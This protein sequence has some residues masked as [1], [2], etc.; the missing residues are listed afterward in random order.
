MFWRTPADARDALRLA[1]TKLPLVVTSRP[2]GG[3]LGHLRLLE[4]GALVQLEPVGIDEVARYLAAGSHGDKPWQDAVRAL[5]HL[6]GPELVTTLS[7][8]LMA[9]LA[10]TVYAPRLRDRRDL[11]ELAAGGLTERAA[12]EEHLLTALVPEAF[13]RDSLRPDGRL[14]SRGHYRQAHLWLS[15][16]ATKL[17]PGRRISFWTL[18]RLAPMYRIGLVLAAVA[19]TLLGLLVAVFP[20]L[21]LGLVVA[22]VL[23]LFFGLAF[24]RAYARSRIL[25]PGDPNR[26]GFGGRVLGTDGDWYLHS[27]RFAFGS[28]LT[29]VM[30]GLVVV[31][32]GGSALQLVDSRFLVLVGA[33]VVLTSITAWVGGSFAAAV[34]RAAPR[35]DSLTGARARNP[36]EV[37]AND[38]RSGVGMAVLAWAFNGVVVAAVLQVGVGGG[39]LVGLVAGAGAVPSAVSLFNAWVNYKVAHLWLVLRNRLPWRVVDFLHEA[40]LNGVLRQNGITYEFRHDRLR[41]ALVRSG[42]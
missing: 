35:L 31:V 24:V 27:G 7:S 42:R 21:A 8:P 13:R 32:S 5:R 22:H 23:G 12:I 29:V 20:R 18:S 40:H 38:R 2:L 11:G 37:V 15:F 4:R 3:D 26:T 19:G 9:W 41:E 34:L 1:S 16:L 36:V 28:F 30:C 39:L 17:G 14:D 25:R 6:A 33:V 10:C